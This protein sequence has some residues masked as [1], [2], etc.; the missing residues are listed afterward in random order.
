[1]PDNDRHGIAIY[2]SPPPT[3][4]QVLAA[5]DAQVAA[6]KAEQQRRNRERLAWVAQAVEAITRREIRP[7]APSKAR[8]WTLTH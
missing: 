7:P 2:T 4:T 3:R 1:M 6:A 8:W 5:I